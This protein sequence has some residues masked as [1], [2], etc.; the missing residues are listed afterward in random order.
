M[1]QQFHM[2]VVS[3][4]AVVLLSLEAVAVR[5]VPSL[6]FSKLTY[7]PG[8]GVWTGR[9]NELLEFALFGIQGSAEE[10]HV[11]GQTRKKSIRFLFGHRSYAGREKSKGALNFFEEKSNGASD[12]FTEGGPRVRA[13]FPRRSPRVRAI[14]RLSGP[15]VTSARKKSRAPLD[16]RPEKSRARVPPHYECRSACP[17]VHPIRMGT[18]HHVT[19][20][21][22][23]AFG[24]RGHS[25]QPRAGGRAVA[26]GG[27]RG[28]MGWTGRRWNG[29]RSERRGGVQR[30]KYKELPVN[31]EDTTSRASIWLYGRMWP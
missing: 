4:C 5:S 15:R 1:P 14:F 6:P 18:V 22:R 30:L 11:R 21:T 25:A 8:E 27:G 31:L 16:W 29:V 20:P 24:G 26:G 17:R 7:T 3:P 9:T 12:F 2:N 23:R 19:I 10:E 13:I 28:R